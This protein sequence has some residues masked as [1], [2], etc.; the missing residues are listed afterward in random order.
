MVII[1]EMVQILGDLIPPEK[2][3]EWINLLGGKEPTQAHWVDLYQKKTG[4]APMGVVVSFEEIC[5]LNPNLNALFPNKSAFDEEVFP[6]LK[7]L[8]REQKPELLNKRTDLAVAGV[9]LIG[10]S[11]AVAV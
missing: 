11:I 4:K 1:P 6:Q 10:Q 8:V 3:Q 2:V 7:D 9:R 5:K